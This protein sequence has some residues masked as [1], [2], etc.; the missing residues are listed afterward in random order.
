MT[1]LRSLSVLFLQGA[2]RPR[3]PTGGAVLRSHDE[4]RFAQVL[5]HLNAVHQTLVVWKPPLGWRSA[6]GVF[7]AP[8]C[9]SSWP[10]RDRCAT[11][12]KPPGRWLD[13]D[14]SDAGMLAHFAEVMR[15]ESRPLPDRQTQALTAI[16]ARHQQLV[17]C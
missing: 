15:P 7:T 11:S 6:H 17:E 10:I 12:P 8:G 4:A 1:V 3:P 13:A 5:E 2:V 14:A 16:L 9:R